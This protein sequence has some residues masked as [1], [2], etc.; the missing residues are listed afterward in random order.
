MP[1]AVGHTEVDRRTV[2][3]EGNQPERRMQAGLHI[4][5]GVVQQALHRDNRSAVVVVDN[6]QGHRKL[7]GRDID[8]DIG[9]LVGEHRRGCVLAGLAEHHPEEAGIG[10]MG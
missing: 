6:Q 9:L 8:Q 3:V 4:V 10:R 5:E 7:V 2:A 1:A